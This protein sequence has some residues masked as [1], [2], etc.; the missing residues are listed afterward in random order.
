MSE[1]GPFSHWEQ[2][3]QPRENAL[4]ASPAKETGHLPPLFQ[5]SQNSLQDYADCARRFQLRYIDGQRW[6]AAES[7]PI[8]EQERLM[9]Q[10]TEFHLLVQRHILGLPV[11]TL[12]P[13]ERPL[14]D[15]WDAYLTYTPKDLPT[16]IR[17]PEAQLTTPVGKAH[18][19]MARYD[20][21]AID[22][23]ERMVIVDWK[24]TRSRPSHEILARRLQTRVYPFVLAEAGAHLFG[25]PIPPEAITLIYWFV[26]AP[27]Q[28]EVFQYNNNLYAKDRAYL[29]GLIDEILGQDESVWMLTDDDFHCKYCVY[30]SLCERGIRAGRL[31]EADIQATSLDVDFD[32]TF[33]FDEIE[34][35]AF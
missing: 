7:E 9:E 3:I 24:T 14:S 8:E 26:E 10:G 32:F 19:L 16:S 28:P 2:A 6:P 21:L 31:D 29:T 18:R 12:T 1:K 34:E 25:G 22:P 11:E 30:R 5:F 13:Q 4:T 27:T 33:E 23:G 15:W 17:L 35:I 20:L